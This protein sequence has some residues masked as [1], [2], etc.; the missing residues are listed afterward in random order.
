MKQILIN[1]ILISC[2]YSNNTLENIQVYSVDSNSE[3]TFFYYRLDISD[4]AYCGAT[5]FDKLNKILVYNKSDYI[6]CEKEI[7]DGF[8]LINGSLLKKFQKKY[9]RTIYKDLDI[10]FSKPIA[11]KLIYKESI[12]IDFVNKVININLENLEKSLILETINSNKNNKV[13]KSKKSQK[14]NL[15]PQEYV[16]I[17]TKDE[18]LEKNDSSRIKVKYWNDNNYSYNNGWVD[19]DEVKI[20]HLYEKQQFEDK[21]TYETL[22][23]MAYILK[24][25]K[26]ASLFL[27]IRNNKFH[28][29]RINNSTYKS[30][31]SFCKNTGCKE[32]E[33][34]ALNPWINKKATNIP[35]NAEII[36]P[37]MKEKVK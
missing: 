12:A 18:V 36:I 8:S 10:Y 1:I 37:K 7:E 23:D 20:H 31:Y 29:E 24:N 28:I 34:R 30:L 5:V 25:K 6:E 27:H 4:I 26:Q 19:K 16:I 9:Q 2:L 21:Y 3:Y 32:S 35:P 13:Y 14:F 33:I 17:T 22:S 11:Q 15:L